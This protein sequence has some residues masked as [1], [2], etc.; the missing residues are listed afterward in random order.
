MDT[1]PKFLAEAQA[2]EFFK[3]TQAAM[4]KRRRLGLPPVYYRAG[5]TIRYSLDDL[6]AVLERC[7]P[8]AMQ[9]VAAD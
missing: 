2:A 6:V 9:E 3:L 7:E 8:T 1:D 5:R 4:R